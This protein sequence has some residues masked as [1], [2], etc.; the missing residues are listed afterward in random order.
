MTDRNMLDVVAR[1]FARS[2]LPQ[3]D[4]FPSVQ[5]EAV[6]SSKERLMPGL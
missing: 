3:R 4:Y 6:T 2:D 5:L 1:A